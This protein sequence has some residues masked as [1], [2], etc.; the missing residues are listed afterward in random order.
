MH[1][2]ISTTAS[3][4]RECAQHGLRGGGIGEA[5]HPGPAMEAPVRAFAVAEDV[6]LLCDMDLHSLGDGSRV[7][8]PLTADEEVGL[9]AGT[10]CLRT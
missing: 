9:L 2:E 8:F 4:P 5:V 10:T 7:R 1:I 6:V 3:T